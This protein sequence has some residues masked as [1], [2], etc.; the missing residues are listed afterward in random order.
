MKMKKIGVYI[1]S[2]ALCFN[3][4]MAYGCASAE[5]AEALQD[6][7]VPCNIA[8]VLTSCDL[9]QASSAELLCYAKTHVQAGYY[10]GVIV[11]LQQYNGG[12]NTIKTWN[13]SDVGSAYVDKSYSVSRNY[14]YRLRITHLAYD[15]N[16]NLIE[17][18]VKYSDTVYCS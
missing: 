5:A 12:W 11:E 8:I 9:T 10:A 6:E 13:S 14:S 15:L 17:S 2:V 1:L 7:V 3:F 4:V 18:F 16:W